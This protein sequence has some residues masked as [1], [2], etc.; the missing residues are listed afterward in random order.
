[1]A[2]AGNQSLTIF[3]NALHGANTQFDRRFEAGE[4]IRSLVYKRAQF[5]DCLLH[6]LWHQYNWSQHITLI[7]VGGYGRGELHPKSDIDLLLLMDE[8]HPEDL[9]SAQ[10]FL[11][12]LWDLGLEIGSS[13]RTIQQCID[14]AKEDITVATNI[15][16][17]RTLVG[18][19]A[20][21][22][23]L[24]SRS[25]PQNIWPPKEFFKAKWQEQLARHKKHNNTEY[26]LE[27]NIKNAPGGL[28]DI[29]MI[30]WVSK[31]YFNV[32]TLKQLEGR[33][34]FTDSE[35]AQL[36]YGEEFLWRVRYG[37]HKI[38]GR[39]EERLLFDYQRQLAEQ[40]G[41]KDSDRLA[42]EQFM[43]QYY[44]VVLSI[45][46]LNDVLLHYL[47]EA[48]LTDPDQSTVTPIN[49]NFQLRDQYIEVT[50]DNVFKEDP[51]AL[52]E[53]FVAMGN[54]ANINGVRPETIRL[55]RENRSLIDDDFRK[56]PKNIELFLRLLSCEASLTTQLRRMKRYNI[57][58]RY[59]PEFGKIIGQ[60]QHDLFHI[61]TVDAHTLFLINNLRTFRLKSTEEKFPIAYQ[62]SN[63]IRKPW[64]LYIAGLYHDIGKGRGGNHATL[65]A[66][67]ALAFGERHGLKPHDTRFIAWLVEKHLLMSSVSQKQDI[68]DPEVI[69][70]FAVEMGDQSHLNYLY[71]LTVADINA[72]N[73]TLWTTWRASLMTQLYNETTSVLL[74]GL[75]NP[76]DKQELI[77]ETQQDAR[78]A[79][80]D[81]GHC[82][83]NID[84][85]WGYLGDEYFLQ[86]SVDEI[87][88]QSD[89]IVNHNS[90]NDLIAVRETSKKLYEGATEIFIRARDRSYIFAAVAGTLDYLN[91]NIVDAR[92]Y[93]TGYGGYTIDTFY[94]L[95]QNNMP[96]G[97]DPAKVQQIHAALNEELASLDADPDIIKRRTPRQLKHFAIPTRTRLSN[98]NKNGT[99]VLEVTSP[100]RPGLLA[101]I[102]RIFIQFDIHV[103]KAKISTLGE[104]VEDTFFIT[105]SNDQPLTDPVL[106]KDLQEAI[107]NQL[108]RQVEAIEH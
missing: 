55:L 38:A 74:R 25:R 26:N 80:I 28:R 52:I 61:Y 15:M 66:V 11:T 59:L 57:L 86:E 92:I 98:D 100:D 37:L 77:E 89:A 102:A 82:H 63:S 94:V 13:V 4:D 107:C 68:S 9:E 21:T 5:I 48:L 67:D 69:H 91:L 50:H 65:G 54:D 76:I 42:V 45:R 19:D 104:R 101:L 87:T 34:F 49:Q 33:D 39:P 7:A 75:E 53:I 3:K 99:T 31:R 44:R 103:H 40:L 20:I 2:A 51:S 105:G 47:D 108:D 6:Y 41:Y 46:E 73:P 90:K 83:N 8:E 22:R 79:L 93:N 30:S 71:L 58:G 106:S 64:L 95:D 18:N 12:Y 35:F 60:M 43:H 36:L 72:T 97:N 62:V 84:R 24:Q 10:G 81:K 56:D 96:I 16:E 70:R 23:E 14:I 1:M 78:K 17:C 29:Q 88:W 27:P 32:K 85:L